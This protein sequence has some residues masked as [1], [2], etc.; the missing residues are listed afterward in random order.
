MTDIDPHAGERI[1]SAGAPPQATERV[2]VLLHGRGDSPAGILRLV[3]DIYVRGVTYLAP[4]AAGRVWY[5]GELTDPVTD[6]RQAYLD[7]AFGQ[8]ERALDMAESM[9]IGTEDVTL[10]GFSQGASVA[11]E[12]V[13]AR[14]RRYGGLVALAGGLLG[15]T[16]GIEPRDGN[17]DGMPAVCGVGSENPHISTEH[18]EATAAALSAMGADASA[19][20]YSGVG[21]AIGDGA[22]DALRRLS[23]PD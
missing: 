16:K 15:P 3:D 5:P 22:V 13:V 2:V 17:L 18:A 1:E 9:G 14:P 12:F 6:R 10:A 7:S 23:R 19:E 21:H 8:V 11:S 20:T 4:A